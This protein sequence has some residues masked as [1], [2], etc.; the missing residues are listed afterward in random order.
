MHILRIRTDTYKYFARYT[1]HL[2]V[3]RA[4]AEIDTFKEHR[5]RA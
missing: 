4:Q 5:K 1:C 2:R 3:G